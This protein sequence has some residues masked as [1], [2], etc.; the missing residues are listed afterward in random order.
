VGTSSTQAPVAAS[1]TSTTTGTKFMFRNVEKSPTY[2]VRFSLRLCL[3]LL[4]SSVSSLANSQTEIKLQ[5]QIDIKT[6]ISVNVNTETSRET[7]V[8]NAIVEIVEDRRNLSI[9]VEGTEPL[10]TASTNTL[11]Q[12]KFENRSTPLAWDISNERRHNGTIKATKVDIKID[13]NTGLL[14]FSRL[15]FFLSGSTIKETGSGYCSKVDTT[16]KKF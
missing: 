16:K 14:T 15:A 10:A 6:E 12:K 4:T 9:T 8:E 2:K 11:D 7:R 1:T 3:I 5:C 13:R